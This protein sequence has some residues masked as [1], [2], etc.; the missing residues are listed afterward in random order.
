MKHFYDKRIPTVLSILVLI[1]GVIVTTILVKTGVI[2]FGH[3]APSDAPQNI[4]I[5]N[6]TDTA[7]TITYTTDASVIGTVNLTNTG[8]KPQVVL[9]DRDQTAGI[10]K[11]YNTHSISVKNLTAQTPYSFSILSGTTTY[12]DGNNPFT[13]TTPAKL[14]SQPTDQAP[15]AGKIVLPD[16]TVPTETLVF[17]T[18]DNGQLLSTLLNPS[19]LYILPLNTMRTKDFSNFVLFTHDNKLHVLATNGP[20]TTRAIL[21]MDGINPAPAMTLSQDYD[22]TISTTPLASGAASAFP[23]FTL[24]PNNTYNATP[25]I[26]FPKQN[27]SFAD[28]QPQFSGTA[29]PNSQVTVTIH[30][31]EK[32]TTTVKTSANG[33]WSY[34]PD[35]PLSPG[36]HTITITAPDQF[37]ILRT[38][39]QSFTVYAAGTQVNQSATPSATLAPTKSPTKA[40]PTPTVVVKKPSPTIANQQTVTSPSP[41][42]TATRLLISPKPTLP[43]TGSN[44]VAVVSLTGIATVIVGVVLFL[45]TSGATL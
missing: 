4:R 11:P 26:I 1:V 24:P 33:S 32:I 31:D 29:S 44:T 37:G 20:L 10:P 38:I 14:T 35:K 41:I 21:A 16:G 8:D 6:I 30:S 19:G 22:F 25:Q 23:N 7:F 18:T 42:P 13:F 45:V 17:V 15:L 43:P 12:L 39:Q 5:T 3:A 34:R 28:Q 36:L 2:I 27:E 9:D 40:T